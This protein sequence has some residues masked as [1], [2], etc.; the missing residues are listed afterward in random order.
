MNPNENIVLKSTML[1]GLFLGS[2][3]A[4]IVLISFLI[5]IDTIRPPIFITLISYTAVIVIIAQATKKYRDNVLGGAITYG[6]AFWYGV[7]ICVFAGMIYG[8]YMVIHVNLIDTNFLTQFMSAVEEEY[9][10]IG[11][12]EKEIADAMNALG[13]M[14]KPLGMVIFKIFEV[15]FMG[16]V[17]SLFISIFT[18]KRINTI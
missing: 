4:I 2:I 6:K 1:Y 18:K 14:Q 15:S 11:F 8:V 16:I 3:Q 5:G 7:L 17:F 12:N 10:N 13:M 9:K